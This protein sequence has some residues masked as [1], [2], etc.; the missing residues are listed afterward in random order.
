MKRI[1]AALLV[2]LAFVTAP[3]SHGQERLT[4][5][6]DAETGNYLQTMAAP[7]LEHMNLHD[8]Q[9][10]YHIVSSDQVNAFVASARDVYFMTGLINK[11]DTPDE[12]MG[13]LA[14]ELGHLQGRHLFR[15]S[16]QQDELRIPSIIAG[17][18]GAGAVIAG[19]PQAGS[20]ILIG[21]QAAGVSNLL[22]FTRAQEQQADQIAV[23]ALQ[24]SGYSP[25][26]MESFF[27]KLRT[28]EVLYTRTP[29]PYLLT[30]PSPAQRQDFLANAVAKSA[31]SAV[32]TL[33]QPEFD[34]IKAKLYAL[35]ESPTRVI[36]KYQADTSFAG[37]YALSIAYA[38][39]AKFDKAMP[40]LDELL[41][42]A[43]DDAY[44]LELKSQILQ[45]EGKATEALELMEQAL[46]LKPDEVLFRYQK[47][48]LLLQLEQ[49][50]KALPIL[51]TVRNDM[52]DWAR[53]HYLL[54]LTYGKLGKL[55][56]SHISLAES[57]LLQG[58]KD[59][60]LYHVQLA[61]HHLN[62]SDKAAQ[63]KLSLMKQALENEKN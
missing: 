37:R 31:G 57:S 35:S 44:L 7:L 49:S 16:V 39:Q 27:K 8:A 18:L 50:D 1:L 32:N 5:L 58:L 43:P 56:L 52:P 40:L 42:S 62:Q 2:A 28:D 36:R 13:V 53:L 60:A 12:V 22:R 34:R 6:I 55:S 41:N 63:E 11:A 23:N 61:E 9:L 59:D 4:L 24:A 10:R 25:A 3:T 33:S 54:G 30:H 26:G 21:A 14:H 29:P 47:A 46:S 45:D 48:E 19:A 20:A 51:L 15:A 38:R 17:V